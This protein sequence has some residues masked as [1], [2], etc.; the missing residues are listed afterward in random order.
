MEKNSLMKELGSIFS[1][2][3]IYGLTTNNNATKFNGLRTILKYIWLVLF[4]VLSSVLVICV[5]GSLL[6]YYEIRLEEKKSG[7]LKTGQSLNHWYINT[8][9]AVAFMYVK[10]YQPKWNKLIRSLTRHHVGPM[11]SKAT[12]NS[13]NYIWI[14]IVCIGVT[15]FAKYVHIIR[16]LWSKGDYFYCVVSFIPILLFGLLAIF[17][18]L[19]CSFFYVVLSY[20]PL[21][22]SELLHERKFNHSPLRKHKMLKKVF[23]ESEKLDQLSTEFNQFL[24]PIFYFIRFMSTITLAYCIKQLEVEWTYLLTNSWISRLQLVIYLGFYVWHSTLASTENASQMAKSRIQELLNG[25]NSLTS[26]IYESRLAWLQFHDLINFTHI[27][28]K[29]T[30]GT[31]ANNSLANTDTITLFTEVYDMIDLVKSNY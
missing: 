4:T 3:S 16:D 8:I 9:G 15:I 29:T 13:I 14:C 2:L 10:A 25:R 7:Y 11:T 28:I 17:G 20:I 21:R 1:S 12:R 31:M 27:R 22:M 24:S 19:L 5:I 18:I 23:E 6:A 26:S 30:V